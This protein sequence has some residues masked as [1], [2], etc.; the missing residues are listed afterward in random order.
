MQNFISQLV[1]FVIKLILTVFGLV[2]AISLLLAALI[3]VMLSLLKSAITGKKP[4]PVMVFSRFQKFA[5]EGMWPGGAKSQNA[6]DMVDVEA[7][8]VQLHGELLKKEQ[9]PR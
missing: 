8:E 4:A 5:P 7:R 6:S 3:V 1:R 2:F 9:L